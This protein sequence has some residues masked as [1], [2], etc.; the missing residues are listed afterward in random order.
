MG[1]GSTDPETGREVSAGRAVA[2]G[3]AAASWC[4]V[5]ALPWAA[6]AGMPTRDIRFRPVARWVFRVPQALIRQRDD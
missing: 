2:A 6:R 1:V 3:S 5:R 4:A